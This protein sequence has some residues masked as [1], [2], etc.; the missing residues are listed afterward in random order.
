MLTAMLSGLV[1]EICRGRAGG[2]NLF[3]LLRA[4]QACPCSVI[5]AKA[6]IHPRFVRPN[7]APS[8]LRRQES[9]R[10]PVTRKNS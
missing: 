4:R 1:E 5:P 8:F 6:E 2:G 3:T 7:P 10:D 9:I